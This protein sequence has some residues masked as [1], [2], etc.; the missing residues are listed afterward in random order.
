M[1]LPVVI[2]FRI[3]AILCFLG[4][5]QVSTV[6]ALTG[7]AAQFD[8]VSNGPLVT[9]SGRHSPEAE[10]V[11]IDG[12]GEV[13]ASALD[14]GSGVFSFSFR[15][16]VN[17][18]SNLQIFAVDPASQTNPISLPRNLTIPLLLP[19][20]I[21]QNPNMSLDE[22]RVGVG[23]YTHPGST[24]EVRL[25]GD[26][27]YESIT[28]ETAQGDGGWV[29]EFSNLTPGQ[30]RLTATAKSQTYTSQSSLPL[31]IV[32]EPDVLPKPVSQVVKR[33]ETSVTEVAQ[34]VLPQPVAK[35]VKV[36]APE[37][38]QVAEVVTPVASAGLA[39]QVLLAGRDILYFLVQG[40]ISA[41]QYF[42]FWRKRNP[43]GIVYD[44][45]TKQ[46][47]ML[48]T[49][50]LYTAGEVKRLVE[51]DV[52]SKVGVFSF[53]P[54]PGDYR[55][56]VSKPGYQFPSQ[57][58]VSNVDGEYAHVYHGERV[59]LSQSAIVDVAIP[60]DPE[61]TSK[62]NWRF[63]LISFFRQRLYLFTQMML[64]I[65][66][67]M[68]LLSLMGGSGGL[69]TLI[70][71][72][73][74][75][76]LTGQWYVYFRRKGSWGVVVNKQGKP[77]SGI[78]LNLIDPQFNKLVQRRITDKNGRYQFIVPQ[79]RYLIQV[80]T[81]D[82]FLVTSNKQSYQGQEIWVEG[83]KPKLISI[84]IIVEHESAK[85]IPSP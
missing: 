52:T 58:V 21:A 51:T 84:K 65:G 37:A 85:A 77:I 9:V 50:R 42:G 64:V 26:N 74:C 79:G 28:I 10:I 66:F 53:E 54:E 31:Q 8:R 34:V 36:V 68:S 60:V 15:A 43:W 33:V 11:V 41:L 46:P 25:V 1:K 23:G 24:V 76:V 59:H 18:L 5:Y 49:V 32:V 83:E 72:F 47:I 75:A 17:Q 57:L 27:G 7:V 71:L 13:V 39:T 35:A 6:R 73:Y 45:I 3:F 48:A 2:F 40:G 44:A 22:N 55:I 56:Q 78:Q 20:S 30:Y 62:L 69:N 16:N 80:E 4:T 61:D 14:N 38:R 67:V 82:Y 29:A 12:N 19:P 81:V 63:R 70:L